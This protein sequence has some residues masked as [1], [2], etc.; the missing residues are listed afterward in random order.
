VER[1]Y[2]AGSAFV[3]KDGRGFA[4]SDHAALRADFAVGI[5]PAE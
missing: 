5:P 3:H 2:V 1:F 4:G